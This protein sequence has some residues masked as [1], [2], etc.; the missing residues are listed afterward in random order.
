MS[1]ISTAVH[2]GFIQ[3]SKVA[4]LLLP[5]V[6]K[7]PTDLEKNFSCL[8][9]HGLKNPADKAFHQWVSS[10]R[11][12]IEDVI[13]WSLII[14]WAIFLNLFGSGSSGLWVY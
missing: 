6:E 3:L 4:N 5:T 2:R 7:R 12:K 1:S 8:I 11:G 9:P 10:I 13:R 14:S